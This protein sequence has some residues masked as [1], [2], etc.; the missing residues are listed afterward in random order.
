M[1]G[2][3]EEGAEIFQWYKIFEAKIERGECGDVKMVC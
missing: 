2:K 3:T 1:T